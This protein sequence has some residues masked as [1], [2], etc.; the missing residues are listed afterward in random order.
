[1]LILLLFSISSALDAL[2]VQTSYY[3]SQCPKTQTAFKRIYLPSFPLVYLSVHLTLHDRDPP[4]SEYPTPSPT[5]Y[6]RYEGVPT[7]LVHD[8]SVSLKHSH[9]GYL[10]SQAYPP[11]SRFLTVRIDGGLLQELHLFNAY[12]VYGWNYDIEVKA[13]YCGSG[14]FTSLPWDFSRPGPGLHN[15]TAALVETTAIPAGLAPSMF[16][17][18]QGTARLS[19]NTEASYTLSPYNYVSE[20]TQGDTEFINPLTGWWFL[21]T[22]LTDPTDQFAISLV[23]CDYGITNSCNSEP[24]VAVDNIPTYDQI[25][26]A[27]PTQVTANSS[28]LHLFFGVSPEDS[29]Y[30]FAI[31]VESPSFPRVFFSSRGISNSSEV[32]TSPS[33]LCSRSPTGL[34][35]ELQYLQTGVQY[36]S[37][38]LDQSVQYNVSMVKTEAGSDMCH[39]EPYWD[40]EGIAYECWCLRNKAG[41]YCEDLAISNGLYMTSVMLLTTSNLAMIPALVYGFKIKMIVEVTGYA[42]NMIA[43]YIY[44]FCDENYYCFGTSLYTLMITDFILSFN[45]I[46]LSFIYLARVQSFTHKFSMIFGV[47][48]LL[49]YL[50][51]DNGLFGIIS[52]LL[53]RDIQP[54]F[55]VATIPIF[56]YVYLISKASRKDCGRCWN[57]KLAGK[58]FY[59]FK[60]FRPRWLLLAF[61]SFMAALLA[62]GFEG[63]YNYYIVRDM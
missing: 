42:A 17:V 54:L 40:Y 41:F 62:R 47:L 31:W 16:F 25:P 44:H 1:M 56:R 37:I 7:A 29:K 24:I 52:S 18:P 49:I 55:I 2:Q 13:Y 58:F 9:K 46:S 32:C 26:S 57:W 60:N 28:V 50:A 8:H 38:Y 27:F 6:S 20:F 45:S 33:F 3:T 43:S 48:V 35:A 53:V 19:I 39:G 63:N 12:T 15:C 61:V 23:D 22:N 4:L 11:F 21:I 14:L 5:A 34:L 30:R 36:L 59:T 10:I 51:V